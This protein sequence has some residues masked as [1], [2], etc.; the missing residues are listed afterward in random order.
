MDKSF[1]MTVIDLHPF[2][3][4]RLEL[5]LWDQKLEEICSF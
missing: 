5:K 3:S 4:K 1:M 2:K